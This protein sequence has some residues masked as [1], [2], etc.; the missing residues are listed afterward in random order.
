[1]QFRP[2]MPIRFSCVLFGRSHLQPVFGY[3]Q[4]VF[5][6]EKFLARSACCRQSSAFFRNSS[7]F[8]AMVAQAMTTDNEAKDIP[9]L[10]VRTP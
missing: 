10:Q 4:P 3:L 6:I 8:D 2:L 1:M 5:F 9:F 7:A